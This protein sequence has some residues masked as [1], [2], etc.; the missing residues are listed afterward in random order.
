MKTTRP[1]NCSSLSI[2]ITNGFVP[3]PIIPSFLLHLDK[4]AFEARFNQSS[5]NGSS[6]NI[7]LDESL[8][9]HAFSLAAVADSEN[10]RVGWLLSSKAIVQLVANLF[11]GPLCSR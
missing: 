3:V 9:K 2:F 10:S 1:K 6:G 11:V 7:L 5:A 8:T 4:Q